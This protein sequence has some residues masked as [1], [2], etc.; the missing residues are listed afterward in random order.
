M[1]LKTFYRPLVHFLGWPLARDF[2]LFSLL[3]FYCAF[4]F[5]AWKSEGIKIEGSLVMY[6]GIE[7]CQKCAGTIQQYRK[8]IMVLGIWSH[9]LQT[10]SVRISRYDTGTLTASA[11]GVNVRW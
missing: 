4:F 9:S 2:R 11:A 3:S 6:K 7:S 8:E 5:Q 1:A 10:E